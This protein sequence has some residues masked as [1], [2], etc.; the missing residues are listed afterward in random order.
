MTAVEYILTQRPAVRRAFA[1][2]LLAT[3]VQLLWFGLIMPA[4]LL[5]LSQSTWREETQSDL[6]RARGTAGIESQVRERLNALQAAAVWQRFYDNQHSSAIDGALSQDITRLANTAGINIHSLTTLP[7]TT[8]GLL[9]RH[10]VRLA[11]SMSIDQLKLFIAALRT[12]TR[13]IRVERL[14]VSAPQ[15]QPPDRNPPLEIKADLFGY[16]R[17]AAGERN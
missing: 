17:A 1:V 3:T 11:A 6:A 10:G 14:S 2:L 12:H 9:R 15:V 5:V 4:H 7:A 8:E 16:N 13:Y